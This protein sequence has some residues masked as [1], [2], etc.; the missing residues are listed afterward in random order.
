MNNTRAELHLHTKMGNMDA[1]GDIEGYISFAKS[2]NISA[3]AV[4]DRSVVRAFPKAYELSKEYGVKLIYGADICRETNAD[5]K[6]GITVLARNRQGLKALYKMITALHTE[7]SC[8]RLDSVEKIISD[9]RKNL[10]VGACDELYQAIIDGK[11][12]DELQAVIGFYDFLEVQPYNDKDINEKIAALGERYDKP[13]AAASNAHYVYAED[14]IG[15]AVLLHRAGDSAP[16][17]IDLHMR[18][19]EEMMEEFAYLGGDMAK[20]VVIKNPNLIA[21]MCDDTFSPFPAEKKKFEI[22]GA[23]KT[24]VK[25]A[26]AKL[27]EMYGEDPN[28]T[29][30]KRFHDE[31]EIITKNNCE[32]LF[33]LAAGIVNHIA[34]KGCL[35]GNR[36]CVGSSFIAYLLEITETNPLKAHYVCHTCHHTE[37]SDTN[38]CGADMP[39]K[40]CPNCRTK[41]K[42]DGFNIPYEPLF[43]MEGEKEPVIDLNIPPSMFDECCK[44]LQDLLGKCRICR[45]GTVCTLSDKRAKFYIREFEERMGERLSCAERENAQNLLC[46]AVYTNGLCPG[47]L[48]IAPEGTRIT[49]YTPLWHTDMPDGLLGSHFSYHDLWDELFKFDI[50]THDAPEMLKVLEDLTGV[51]PAEIPLDDKKTIGSF[52]NIDTA[53][54]PEFASPY[55]QNM[56]HIA[57]PKCFDDLIRISALSHGTGAWKDNAEELIK[58]HK[59]ELSEVISCR[60]DVFLTLLKYGIDRQAAYMIS[61][62][63]RKGKGLSDNDIKL[64]ERHGIPA[65]FIASCQK[66]MYLFPRAHAAV[67]TLMAY[68]IAYCKAH[69]PTEFAK[70]LKEIEGK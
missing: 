40:N 43:G 29:I 53:G 47:G 19:T 35:A 20:K 41:M 58:E 49:D 8:G 38:A 31:L 3:V 51:K 1:V 23:K 2:N 14:K 17:N 39:D 16:S 67:Y 15:E 66:I 45:A 52:Q 56:M 54:I 5:K 9:D 42:K 4:T 62:R 27:E 37:F 55:V 65:W 13:V 25:Q 24:I 57:Q 28:K 21:D 30:K 11:T 33:V 70:A 12:D 26:Q 46:G 10:L 18:T 6:Y 34:G 48:L 64:V 69:Y 63:I 22:K 59:A 61:E 50:L 7:P 44:Y 60:D 32:S 68:R 36:G